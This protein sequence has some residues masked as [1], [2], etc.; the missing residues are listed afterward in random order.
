MQ[1]RLH[2]SHTSERGSHCIVREALYE[3]PYEA[4][5]TEPEGIPVMVLVAVEVRRGGLVESSLQLVAKD[6]WNCQRNNNGNNN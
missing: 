4:G 5:H 3:G 1:E 2:T 6:T